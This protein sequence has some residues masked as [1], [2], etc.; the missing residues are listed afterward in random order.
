[1]RRLRVEVEQPTTLKFLIDSCAAVSVNIAEFAKL[2]RVLIR[3]SACRLITADGNITPS[4]GTVE[5]ILKRLKHN[6][7]VYFQLVE[8]AHDWLLSLPDLADL[9]LQAWFDKSGERNYLVFPDKF[10]W[11]MQQE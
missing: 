5:G 7:K 8:G 11:E 3:N 9:G 1:M 2:F 4:D 10:A 6:F